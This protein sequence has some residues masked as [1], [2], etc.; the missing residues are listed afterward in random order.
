MSSFYMSPGVYLQ[1][2]D[3]SQRVRM[4]GTS[5]GACV[6]GSRRGPLETTYVTSGNQFISLYGKPDPAWS[7]A[8]DCILAYLEQAPMWLTRVTN[9]A[10]WSGLTVLNNRDID[11]SPSETDFV[12]FPSAGALDSYEDGAG[13]V[14]HYELSFSE[15]LVSSN[16]FT[17]NI[18]NG[19][20]TIALPAVTFATDSDTTMLAIAT[21]LQSAL[22]SYFSSTGWA[23]SAVYPYG[24]TT[25]YRSI[26]ITAP[27]AG[28]VILTSPTITGGASQATVTV[29]NEPTLF[30]VY[31]ID[32]GA[33]SSDGTST[34]VGVKIVDVDVGTNQR[35]SLTF[36]AALITGNQVTMSVGGTA[37][38]A[39]KIV[40]TFS[41]GFIT[42]NVTNM[43]ING[44]AIDPVTFTT[45]SAATFQLL[46]AAIDDILDDSFSVDYD[47]SAY[48]ITIVSTKSFTVNSCAVTGG[49]SQPTPSIG[50]ISVLAYVPYNQSND[51]TLKVLSYSI[52]HALVGTIAA[53]AGSGTNRVALTDIPLSTGFFPVVISETSLTGGVSQVS[54]D[55]T[56]EE[57]VFGGNIITGN[58][59]SCEV[60]GVAITPVYF[61][62]S[63][64]Q[65]IIDIATAINKALAAQ[66]CSMVASGIVGSSS[67]R[68][69]TLVSPY[70]G[71]DVTV[72]SV[73]VS[74]GSSQATGVIAETLDGVSPTWQFTLE[75]YT[76][77]NT[78]TPAERFL[79]CLDSQ[80]DGYGNQLNISEVVNDSAGKSS[81]IRI[82]QPSW[83]TDS[84]PIPFLY[85]GRWVCT[86]TIIWLANGADGSVVTSSQISAGWNTLTDTDTYNIR[87]L[88]NGGYDQVS[89]QQT[90]DALCRSRRDC[91]AVLDMP[92]EYQTTSADTVSYRKEVLN[93]N[94][95][96]SALYTPN[97]LIRDEFTDTL[98]YIPPSGH[99]AS[100]YAYTDNNAATWFSP[101][102]IKRGQ[103]YG[104]QG[105]LATYEQA[106]RDLMSP[107]QV[108]AI[109]D[110]PGYG[111]VVWDDQ[112]LQ[113]AASALSYVHVRRLLILIE[114]TLANSYIPSLFD[115]N[116]AF[117]RMQ[118]VQISNSLL[119]TIKQ[120]RGLYRYLVV[121]DSSN[122]SNADVASGQLNVDVYLDP[123]LQVRAIK[124]QSILTATGASFTEL[125]A[126]GVAG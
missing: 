33:W 73:L 52:G 110:K 14:N 124:L 81:Y 103:L 29:S 36:S 42:D 111:Y 65:T 58:I 117:T 37:L 34:S 18:S 93:I 100:T 2:T 7:P 96:Y 120:G 31:S 13:S 64:D 82:W 53:T 122:N 105:L 72:A 17:V 35:Q 98:R 69:L 47:S 83:S 75:V 21:A 45:S 92:D 80:Q 22:N 119:Q 3:I 108:N 97:L 61:N 20:S 12:Y 88:V 118:I 5:T 49:V 28:E 43:T 77:A 68:E 57:I 16:S 26:R 62:T 56:T 32:P 95:S 46:Q 67:A 59:F 55:V 121:C 87:V 50:T 76:R 85:E 10:T 104:V 40:V 39:Q 84:Y 4:I 101:A 114:T 41:T 89:V 27:V 1:E 78:N 63:S 71:T 123:T 116:D 113:A 48:T 23:C 44:M 99:V 112:T 102:G 106:D 15:E 74:G 24:K 70:A 54:I 11:D 8:H 90:M 66:Y 6:F 60:N 9:G 107:A 115:P 51:N 125:I 109:I 79:V 91:I 19:Y 86:P 25:D 38:A 94:S 30:D 126:A